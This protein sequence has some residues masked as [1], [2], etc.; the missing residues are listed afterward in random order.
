VLKRWPV[1]VALVAVLAVLAAAAL[2]WRATRSTDLERAVALAPHAADRLSWTDWAAVRSELDADL[3]ASSSST[4]LE[5]FLD[6]GFDADLTSTSAL[7]GSAIVLH[8]RFGFSPANVDWELF[9][10]SVDGAEVTLQLP[11]SADFDEI[12]DALEELGFERPDDEEG[13]WSGGANLLPD[14]G[15]ELTPELQYVALDADDHL[16]RTSDSKAF[17]EQ[18]L[19]SD[20]EQVEGV[21]DVVEATGEPLSAAIYTGTHACQ[22][23]AMSVADEEDQAQAD[24]LIA[25]AGEVNPVTGFAMSAQPGGG[26]RVVL[27]FEDDD[28]AKTNADSRSA[29]AG[30]PAPG[31]GGDFADRFLVD[32]V[33]AADNLVTMELQPKEGAFVLSDL[34]TGPVLF[35]TC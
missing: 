33:T 13:V 16:V 9:S 6:E 15:P 1:V 8:E 4:E 22:T 11:D 17:L 2:W 34:S 7:V 23:L 27:S 20:G 5:D 12:G 3:S 30:G 28:Q 24:E 19:D 26:V 18:T 21:D 32:S 29:L 31:Q 10:Q 14:I 25:E 35:A